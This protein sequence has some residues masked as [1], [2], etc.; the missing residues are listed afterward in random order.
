MF[1]TNVRTVLLDNGTRV[2]FKNIHTN[3]ENYNMISLRNAVELYHIKKLW[4]SARNNLPK[5]KNTLISI[6]ENASIIGKTE[7]GRDN[8][9]YGDII[10]GF[11]SLSLNGSSL[12][13]EL[14]DDEEKANKKNQEA[15]EFLYGKIIR[16]NYSEKRFKFKKGVKGL[17]PKEQ[18]VKA[19][20]DSEVRELQNGL[21]LSNIEERLSYL[22]ELYEL[23]IEDLK[24]V[25]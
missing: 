15:L 3:Y 21:E 11:I 16:E 2:M 14:L 18:K 20:F 10:Y 1:N 8:G 5:I 17:S 22:K 23:L 19:E 12:H 6:L 7:I 4:T 24:I 9:G 25:A 13:L